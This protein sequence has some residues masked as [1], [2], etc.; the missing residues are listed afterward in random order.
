MKALVVY[1]SYFGNTEKIANAL[2]G[3]LG[4]KEDVTLVKADK[5]KPE[6]LKDVQLLVV[7][8]PTRGARPS[9][10]IQKFIKS[11][12]PNGLAGVKFTAFDT[13]GAIEH[14]NSRFLR[15]FMRTFGFA[16]KRIVKGLT[17]KGGTLIVPPQGFIVLDTKGPLKEGEVE[18]ASSWAKEIA[19]KASQPQ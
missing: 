13:R 14:V 8:S 7:G 6:Q 4:P 2:A 3:A 9:E 10:N 12:P 17:K 19:S 1:D 11:I 15:W 16:E 18:R 5:L